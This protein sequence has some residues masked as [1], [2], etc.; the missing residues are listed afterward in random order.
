[1]NWINIEEKNPL[2]S[3]RVIIAVYNPKPN[4]KMHFIDFGYRL[5]KVWFRQCCCKGEDSE[6]CTKDGYVT[7]WMPLPEDP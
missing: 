7:H 3:A 4:I 6:V 2:Q 5:G 1:M